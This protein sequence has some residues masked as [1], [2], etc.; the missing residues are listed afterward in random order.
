MCIS[1]IIL[2]SVWMAFIAETC[3]WSL[4]TNKV[5]YRLDL[6]YLLIYLKHKGDVL[7]KNPK[8]GI[9]SMSRKPSWKRCS[10]ELVL[11]SRYLNASVILV[12][13][14]SCCPI[15]ITLVPFTPGAKIKI[16]E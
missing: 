9:V 7:L 14:I 16:R 6:Y 13:D 1:Y 11:C 12:R 2:Y 3:R 8:K 5:V 4:I 10:V 15:L